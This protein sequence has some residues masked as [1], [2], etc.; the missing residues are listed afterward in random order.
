MSVQFYDASIQ[1]VLSRHPETIII[2]E[3]DDDGYFI[4]ALISDFCNDTAKFGIIQSNGQGNFNST[5]DL[6]LKDGRYQFG[7]IRNLIIIRDADD[8]F[9][10]KIADTIV[11]LRKIEKNLASIGSGDVV[12]TGD[13]RKLGLFVVSEDG[14]TGDLEDLLLRTIN[15]RECC[16]IVWAAADDFY[17]IH[18]KPKN[19]GK[20]VVRAYISFRPEESTG[21]GRAFK[22]K[23][24]ESSHQ[25][26]DPV[27]ELLQKFI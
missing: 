20:S 10:Q 22:N 9:T 17:K 2:V 26:L 6:L 13:G 16:K 25:I 11:L 24:F 3:G 5:L 19:I 4:D 21:V 15:D 18:E 7:K 8:N 1:N 23:I 12:I 27:K 14:K